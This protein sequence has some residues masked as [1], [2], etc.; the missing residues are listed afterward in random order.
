MGRDYR[1]T[2][3]TLGA[4]SDPARIRI[5]QELVGGEKNVSELSET[6]GI[7]L[8]NV[9]HHLTVLRTSKLV[10]SRK[11]GRFVLCSIR[12]DIRINPEEESEYT[13]GLFCEGAVVFLRKEETD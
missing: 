3:V 4:F 7:P 12:E 10:D 1:E 2:A 5:L 6:L 8:V 13:V 11:E 9:S